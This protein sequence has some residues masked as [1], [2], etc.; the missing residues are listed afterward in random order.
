MRD[1]HRQRGSHRGIDRV[2]AV[3]DDVEAHLRR[4]VALRDDHAEPRALRHRAGLDSER[5]NRQRGEDDEENAAD[6]GL[7]PAKVYCSA[8]RMAYRRAM[9]AIGG[10]QAV[11]VVMMLA[12]VTA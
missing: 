4:D 5:G 12:T 2:A 9:T 7:P 8:A 1:R 10:R 6:H 11:L 3:L